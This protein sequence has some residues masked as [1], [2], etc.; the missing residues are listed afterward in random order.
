MVRADEVVAEF[1]LKLA[2]AP[3]G[4]PVTLRVTAELKPPEGLTVAV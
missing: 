2:D 1:G 3:A 4:R